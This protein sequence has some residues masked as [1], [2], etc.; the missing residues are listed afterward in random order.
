MTI[1]GMNPNREGILITGCS[2]GIGRAIAVH[3]AKQGF[4]VFATVRKE[5]EAKVYGCLY[6][7]SCKLS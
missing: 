5:T 2:S 6:G 1:S 4:T 3:L 7:K